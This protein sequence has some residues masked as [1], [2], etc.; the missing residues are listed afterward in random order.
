MNEMALLNLALLMA[1]QNLLHLF[2]ERAKPGKA[3]LTHVRGTTSKAKSFK[4]SRLGAFGRGLQ[5]K[6]HRSL[7][8]PI[9][10]QDDD[11]LAAVAMDKTCSHSPIFYR[12]NRIAGCPLGR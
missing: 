5:R 4:G 9:A 8:S 12:P 2:P 7:L 6:R 10:T 3:A 11:S 1:A